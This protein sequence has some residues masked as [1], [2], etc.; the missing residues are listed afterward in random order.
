MRLGIVTSNVPVFA[1]DD[2]IIRSVNENENCGY[3]SGRGRYPRDCRSPVE[4]TDADSGDTLTYT[5]VS[6][7][8]SS[9]ATRFSIDNSGQLQTEE[10]LDHEDQASYML[11]V[12]ATDSTGNSA[13][14]TVTVNVNDVNE[15]PKIM[16]GGLA[17]SGSSS[18]Y[19]AE[20]RTDDVAVY[21]ALGPDAAGATW[22]LSGD[23]GG[24]FN[25]TSAGEFTF[26]SSPDYE[27][28]RGA[29]V[30]TSNT[31]TYMVTV[32]ANDGTNEAMRAV[33]VMVT[34]VDEDGMVK[35]SA[36]RPA[37]GTELTATL[38]GPRHGG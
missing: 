22:S 12:K 33:T 10:M 34:N 9:G 8:P 5:I 11:E 23:D 27:M 28:P 36:A 38:T 1:E 19:Y 18:V 2:P 14:V 7:V 13:M 26:R 37:V 31:N 25:I 20:N 17:I 35:L 32:E 6:A 15:S 16:V 30:S 3:G 29:A 4:A 24:Y 21:T